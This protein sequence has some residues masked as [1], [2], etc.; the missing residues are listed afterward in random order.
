MTSSMI[1]EI[2]SAYARCEDLIGKFSHELDLENA[3]VLDDELSAIVSTRIRQEALQDAINKAADRFFRHGKK[4]QRGADVSRYQEKR[5]SL[6]SLIKKVEKSIRRNRIVCQD[7]HTSSRSELGKMQR[8]QHTA[9]KNIPKF[10]QEMVTA[11]I[12]LRR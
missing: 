9:K 8:V 1:F 7:A 10:S 5:R 11:N 2:D 4:A 12:D 6:N 3:A